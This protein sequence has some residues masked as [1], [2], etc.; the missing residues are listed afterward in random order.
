MVEILASAKSSFFMA[1]IVV[2]AVFIISLIENSKINNFFVLVLI[3]GIIGSLIPIIFLRN[4][5]NNE[6]RKKIF[7]DNMFGKYRKRRLRQYHNNWILFIISAAVSFGILFILLVPFTTIAIKQIEDDN[8][9][10]SIIV[11]PSDSQFIETLNLLQLL[12]LLTMMYSW[13]SILAYLL[14]PKHQFYFAEACLKISNDESNVTEKLNYLIQSLNW[15][16]K[17]LIKTFSLELTNVGLIYRKFLEL[18]QDKNNKNWDILLKAFAK[19]NMEPLP[20]L[21]DICRDKN[22]AQGEINTKDVLIKRSHT[23]HIK[24]LNENVL[25]LVA[26]IITVIGIILGK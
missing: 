16:N 5:K 6:K 8:P 12:F 19:N 24:A 26:I 9:S 15:Y 14:F 25:P 13:G 20:V 10:I 18:A 21:L 11:N 1:L 4:V 17:Y 7:R 23:K 3:A 22:H 2:V